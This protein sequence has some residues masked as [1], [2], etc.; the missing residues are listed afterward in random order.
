M[1]MKI[2][3][4]GVIGAGEY[5]E[6]RISGSAAVKGDV[7]CKSFHCS[8]SVQCDGVLTCEADVH[9]S[10]AIHMRGKLTAD[11]IH[12]SGAV[13]GPEVRAVNTVKLSGGVKIDGLLAG[14]DVRVSGGL[15]V[16]GI[17]AENF[18]LSGAVD[19]AGLLNA[20]R[21]ELRLS[22]HD[23]TV[24]SIGGAEVCVEPDEASLGKK[25]FFGS[26][27][28]HARRSGT[29]KVRESVEADV[30]ELVNTE[31]P[32]VTGGRV[33]IG[34]GCRIGT[35]RYR[36]SLTADPEAEIGSSEKI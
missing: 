36:E 30:V 5:D 28:S 26:L 20:E 17:E 31:C 1:D 8:G 12:V 10:G 23:S 32:L 22:I 4:A 7:G 18:F 9:V 16:G 2:S 13:K 29:L 21:A 33:T 6:I 19:C 25:G 15:Q 24:L 35:V 11:E 3:G 27:F 34:K 14:K